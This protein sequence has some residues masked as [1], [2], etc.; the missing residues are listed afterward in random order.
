M[1]DKQ[2]LQETENSIEIATKALEQA[3][4]T[5]KEIR[6]EMEAQVSKTINTIYT[7]FGDDPKRAQKA[8]LEM[9]YTK[10]DIRAC[11]YEVGAR[12]IK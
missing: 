8:V 10:D 7:M 5:A 1:T 11:G 6:K 2:L 4:I 12:G 9:G 3:A